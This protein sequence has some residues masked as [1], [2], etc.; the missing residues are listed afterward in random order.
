MK[1]ILIISILALILIISSK[2]S[3][4]QNRQLFDG[5]M[6]VH[7]GYMHGTIDEISYEAKGMNFG[8]GGVLRFHI[9]KHFRL[10]GEG[11]VSTLKQ[12]KN[13]S[14]I[15]TGCGGLTADA[16]WR[17]GRWIPYLGVSVG[18]GKASTLL[19]FDGSTYDWETEKNIIMHSSPFFFITPNVGLEFAITE[20]VHL[21]I[22]V[23]RQFPI[24]KNDIPS[25]IRFYFG[26]IFA[27]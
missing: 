21:T 8:L 14:Y 15:R 24:S 3:G 1:K 5:G 19:M 22:R 11:Y 4:A 25:G 12:M 23:D 9:G 2:T 10:G 20:S 13:G 7:T 16:Y 18:G 17:F 27:H 26:F 6:M